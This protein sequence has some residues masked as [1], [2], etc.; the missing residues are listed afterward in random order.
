MLVVISIVG[1]LAAL[2]LPAVN[3]AREAARQSACQNNLRQIGLGMQAF[4]A[5]SST[6][7]CSGSFD[8]ER[9]GA[10]TE[11]GWVADLV[12]S[13]T[14]I[15]KML[16]PSN[17]VRISQ[18]FNDLMSMDATVANF[19]SCVNRL[20]TPPTTAP[21]GTPIVNA[22]RQMAV[23]ASLT[24]GSEARR[25]HV[26]Q[27]IL[28]KHYN[29]NYAASWYLVRGEVSLDQSGNLIQRKAGCGADLK[30]RNSTDGPLPL[31]IVDSSGLPASLIPIMGD[32]TSVGTLTHEMGPNAVGVPIGASMTGGPV[33]VTTMQAPSFAAGTPKTGAAGW[34]GVW[35]KQ[36]LQDYRAFATVHR[37]HANILFA[38]MSIRTF[39]DQ[40]GDGMLNNGFPAGVGGFS[41]DFVEIPE[42][43]I[44]SHYSIT[45]HPVD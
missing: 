6:K 43:E 29:T 27:K 15:G 38:D 28:D 5:S 31:S 2:L 39:K 33:L 11:I 30:S 42:K 8:W 7:L 41:S 35:A 21:D 16:C 14:P 3:A 19:N 40:N 22:C 24:P 1:V 25:V 23:D 45:N 32:A 12:N 20:G 36:T 26:E 44:E 18:T 37:A 34:W 17:Q 9:D 13:G 4:A 10:V